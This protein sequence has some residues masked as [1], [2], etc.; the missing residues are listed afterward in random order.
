ME[1][2]AAAALSITTLYRSSRTTSKKAYN[3]GYAS[4]C[5]DLL[6]MIQ[7]AVSDSESEGGSGM[8]TIERV[9][10]WVEARLEA[11]RARE[12]EEEEDEERERE[13]G[14]ADPL[15]RVKNGHGLNRANSAPAAQ[16]KDAVRFPLP[17]HNF[18][19]NNHDEQAP[20]TSTS[21]ASRPIPTQST[22]SSPTMSSVR[23]PPATVP[24]LPKSRLSNTHPK[25]P[26]VPSVSFS[27]SPSVA[28]TTM[29]LASA[30]PIFAFRP[31]NPSSSGFSGPAM[32][33]SRPVSLDNP[34]NVSAGVKRRHAM[35]M[36]LDSTPSAADG[37]GLPS[38]NAPLLGSTAGSS[39]RRTKS[40]RGTSAQ[41]Q[42]QNQGVE[43]MEIE[44]DGRERK[45]VARR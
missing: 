5:Q 22:P 11:I 35:M 24:R 41:A 40:T 10:D 37:A 20:A 13:K 39:R 8:P 30:E 29:L 9:M 28:A 14:R 26:P 4:A 6:Q 18:I 17:P 16:H 23:P 31:S 25:D 15:S 38:I 34:M 27:D 43:A 7:Q 3:A 12:E 1:M 33:E 45:R 44:E 36:M 21:K 42:N 32:I 2:F 19:L